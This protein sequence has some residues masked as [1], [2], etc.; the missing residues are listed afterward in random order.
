[1]SGMINL[2]DTSDFDVNKVRFVFS[3][4]YRA[5]PIPILDI[6]KDFYHSRLNEIDCCFDELYEKIKNIDASTKEGYSD[7]LK[8]TNVSE[9][10]RC[11]KLDLEFKFS[12]KVAVDNSVVPYTARSNHETNKGRR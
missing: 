6:S 9:Q 2:K 1:M 11:Y 5:P 12:G 3:T 8:A 7:L 10:L 4:G